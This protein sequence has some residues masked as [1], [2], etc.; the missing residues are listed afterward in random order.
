M[1]VQCPTCAR[2]FTNE[3]GLRSHAAHLHPPIN[4][5]HCQA[6]DCLTPARAQIV[7]GHLHVRKWC[8]RHA[9]QRETAAA[10][11]KGSTCSV[12]SCTRPVSQSRSMC[13][14][15]LTRLSKLGNV[16]VDV[17]IGTLTPP[18]LTSPTCHAEGCTRPR[19]K[20]ERMCHTHGARVRW[21]GDPF[22]NIKIPA[23]RGALKAAAAVKLAEAE[24]TANVLPELVGVT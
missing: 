13:A 21:Y 23:G 1:T 6:P 3:Q 12:P 17:P 11:A 20:G 4:D 14:A 24:A 7:N 8:A 9:K 5:G 15:H 10:R 22:A 2:T 18:R 16:M 19:A